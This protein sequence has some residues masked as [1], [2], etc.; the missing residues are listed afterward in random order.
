MSAASDRL[1]NEQRRAEKW[2]ETR[3]VTIRTHQIVEYRA[4]P[5]DVLTLRDLLDSDAMD[6]YYLTYGGDE[7]DGVLPI[8][9][10]LA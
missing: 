8:E 5:A 9:D 1:P 6:L 10:Q 3:G 4:I 2:G 7:V